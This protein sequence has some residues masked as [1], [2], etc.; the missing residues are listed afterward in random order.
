MEY[1]YR[2]EPVAVP[3]QEKN[4]RLYSRAASIQQQL[5][6]PARPALTAHTPFRYRP[7]TIH[8]KKRL[9]IFPSPA[10]I[11]FPARESLVSD[12]LAED[13]KTLTYFYSVLHRGRLI[14]SVEDRDPDSMGSLRS[15]SGTRRAKIENS[16]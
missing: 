14:G 3:V 10:G 8:C 2:P 11:L 9:A 12:I 16:S 1:L 15:V 13:V 5:G 7:G 6:T 4:I